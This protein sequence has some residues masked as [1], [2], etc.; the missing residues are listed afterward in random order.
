MPCASHPF[1]SSHPSARIRKSYIVLKEFVSKLEVCFS[2]I[3]PVT[4]KKLANAIRQKLINKQEDQREQTQPRILIV[5][6]IA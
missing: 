4:H 1:R 5:Y 2:S 6:Q 3:H